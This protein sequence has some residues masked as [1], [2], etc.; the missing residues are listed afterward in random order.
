MRIDF[1]VAPGRHVRDARVRARNRGCY[2]LGRYRRWRE[3]NMR[4]FGFLTIEEGSAAG[5]ITAKTR[6]KQAELELIM[7]N[8]TDT[9]PMDIFVLVG[10]AV[11]YLILIALVCSL[12][13]GPDQKSQ[14]A[15]LFNALFI[16]SVLLNPPVT[17]RG[18]LNTDLISFA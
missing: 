8:K 4:L 3:V 17:I 12:M 5:G 14:S 10:L 11:F 6:E 1:E 18:P 2:G 9:T 7:M 15:S 16:P 13:M